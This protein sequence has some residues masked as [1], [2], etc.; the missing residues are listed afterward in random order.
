MS[1]ERGPLLTYE[2]QWQSGHVETV[3]AHQVLLPLSPNGIFG[4]AFGASQ[5]PKVA[6]RVTFHGEFDGHWR[7]VLTALAEDI[8]SIRDVT[9]S[10]RIEGDL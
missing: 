5:Q 6:P 9:A 1:L 7:M 2:I 10:E 8:R 4:E 3:Q